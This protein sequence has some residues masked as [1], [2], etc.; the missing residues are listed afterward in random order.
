M[1]D[2]QSTPMCIVPRYA[3][4]PMAVSPHVEHCPVLLGNVRTIRAEA[5]YA[6]PAKSNL[7]SDNIGIMTGHSA[8]W[9]AVSAGAMVL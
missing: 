4:H 9:K 8:C 2:A 1:A 5:H 3:G 7:V 6:I